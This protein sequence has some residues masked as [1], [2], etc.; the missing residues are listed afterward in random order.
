M[1]N[2]ARTVGAYSFC[3]VTLR[4]SHSTR[5]SVQSDVSEFLSLFVQAAEPQLGFRSQDLGQVSK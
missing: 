5:G 1:Q 2:S 4:G 3:F